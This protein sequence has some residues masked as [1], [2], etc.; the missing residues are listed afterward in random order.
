MAMAMAAEDLPMNDESGPAA[1]GADAS[2]RPGD[3]MSAVPAGAEWRLDVISDVICPWCYIGKRRLEK[4][5]ALL[6]PDLR[7]RIGW[8]PFELNPDMPRQGME[9]SAYRARKFGSLERSKALDAQ[10]AAAGAEEG[11]RFNF[12]RIS[13]T[14]STFDAHRLIRL[15]GQSGDQNA[16]VDRLFEAYFVEGR[17]IGETEVLADVAARA[18]LDPARVRSLLAGQEG[19]EEVRRDEAAARRAGID[20]VPSFVLDGWVLFSGAVPAEPLADALKR[21]VAHLRARET[22]P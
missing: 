4:A 1:R 8:R 12:D 21:A 9:R 22:A 5:L 15:A 20:G 11:L 10:V 2:E 7:F 14:P 16:V 13:R 17:D 3:S 18:G 6:A 19:V